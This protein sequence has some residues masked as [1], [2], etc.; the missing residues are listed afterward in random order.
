MSEKHTIHKLAQCGLRQA[1]E[2][3]HDMK[4]VVGE[5]APSNMYKC[6]SRFCS[7][8]FYVKKPCGGVGEPYLLGSAIL[9]GCGR[10]YN[11]SA[12]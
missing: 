11:K 9:F 8:Y 3:K 5:N 7:G 4:K 6:R 12:S 10:L 1:K 2:L